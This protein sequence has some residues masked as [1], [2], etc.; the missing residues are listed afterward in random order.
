M[1]LARPRPR[2]RHPALAALEN[3]LATQDGGSSSKNFRSPLPL[4]GASTR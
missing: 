4:I 1:D 2:G 3:L